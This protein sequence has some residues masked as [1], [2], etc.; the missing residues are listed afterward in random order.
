MCAGASG[1]DGDRFFVVANAALSV[2]GTRFGVGWFLC[3]LPLAV[4]VGGFFY[5]CAAS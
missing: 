2:L 1:G 3:D 4:G 5:I